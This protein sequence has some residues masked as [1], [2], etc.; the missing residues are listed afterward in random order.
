MPEGLRGAVEP[1]IERAA[2]GIARALPYPNAFTLL[3]LVAGGAAGYALS[4]RIYWL[5]ALLLLVSGAFDAVDG[6]VARVTGKVTKAGAFLDSNLDRLVEL[7]VYLGIGLGSPGLFPL[8]FLTFGA[9]MMVSYSRARVEGLSSGARPKGF[10][11]GERGVRLAVLFLFLLLGL[12]EV[13]LIA[14][15]LLALETFL[16]RLIIYY[17]F[18]RDSR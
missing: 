2:A 17:R 14:V 18:L 15:L 5:G 13:G 3:G 10:E 12:V 16:E 11:V 6:A 1:Y 7:L 8:S 4:F 9:S